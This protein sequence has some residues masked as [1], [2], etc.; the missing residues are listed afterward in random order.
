MRERERER[1]RERG[2]LY[3]HVSGGKFYLEKI[4]AIFPGAKGTTCTGKSFRTFLVTKQTIIPTY[5]HQKKLSCNK[6]D[7]IGENASKICCLPREDIF[8]LLD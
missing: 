4:I 7:N 3:S 2:Y 5:M 1:E 6:L 8:W